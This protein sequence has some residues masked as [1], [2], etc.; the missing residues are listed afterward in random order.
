MQLK[1]K[2]VFVDKV[3]FKM[4]AGS[5][6]PHKAIEMVFIHPSNDPLSEVDTMSFVEENYEMLQ[7]MCGG[8]HDVLTPGVMEEP[9]VH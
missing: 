8:L 3:M 5:P 1:F 6:D 4:Q 7:E 2:G 9:S